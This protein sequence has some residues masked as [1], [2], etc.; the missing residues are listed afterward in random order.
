MTQVRTSDDL[1]A[2]L[3]ETYTYR[4]PPVTRVFDF[5]NEVRAALGAT[6]TTTNEQ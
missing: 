4:S 6:A 5:Q 3:S 1:R 2:V